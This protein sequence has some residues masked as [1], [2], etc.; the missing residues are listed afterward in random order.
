MKN[1]KRWRTAI[2]KLVFQKRF[3]LSVGPKSG[4]P[5]KPNPS[6]PPFAKGGIPL[7]GKEGL[8]EICERY[9]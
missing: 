4:R 9:V 7:F 3:L 8:G 1:P 5:K 2:E 6:S